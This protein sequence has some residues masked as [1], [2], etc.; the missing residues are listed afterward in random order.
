VDQN[1]VKG[2]DVEDKDVKQK[3][4]NQYLEAFRKG[5]YNYIREDLDPATQQVIPR[6]YFSGGMVKPKKFSIIS[7]P[8]KGDQTPK[9]SEHNRLVSMILTKVLW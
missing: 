1:K 4:Y 6:K 5:V 3:I 2:V 7:S 9:A 8:V